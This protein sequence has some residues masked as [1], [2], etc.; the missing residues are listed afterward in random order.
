MGLSQLGQTTVRMSHGGSN[1]TGL[2]SNDSPVE[3]TIKDR[4]DII[5]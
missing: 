3:Y 5:L 4:F 2:V 1:E